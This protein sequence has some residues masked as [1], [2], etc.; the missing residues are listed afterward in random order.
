LQRNKPQIRRLKLKVK[1]FKFLHELHS[2]NEKI[3]E[4]YTSE[5]MQVISRFR[6]FLGLE[7]YNEI[8]NQSSNETEQSFELSSYLEDVEDAIPEENK[9]LWM[10]KLY[11]D[12]AKI[13]H[14]DINSGL[15][16][17]F[18]KLT[19]AYEEEDE[20]VLISLAYDHDVDFEMGNYFELVKKYDNRIEEMSSNMIKQEKLAPWVWCENQDIRSRTQLLEALN[21]HMNYNANKKQIQMFVFRESKKSLKS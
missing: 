3:L 18:I 11:K 7:T 6:E 4:E 2:E 1:H 12:L 10:K 17:E 5:F 20:L 9:P 15:E 8:E 13:L 21:E 16:K 19:K 14:P